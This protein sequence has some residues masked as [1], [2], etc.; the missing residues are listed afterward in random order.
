MKMLEWNRLW[1]NNMFIF[2]HFQSFDSAHFSVD[3]PSKQQTSIFR[4]SIYY[5]SEM[6]PSYLWNWFRWYSV[7][8]PLLCNRILHY[9]GAKWATYVY[10]YKG[11]CYMSRRCGLERSPSINVAYFTPVLYMLFFVTDALKL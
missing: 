5:L 8:F 7:Y 3:R 11:F 2:S 4:N 1:N 10:I 6:Y 9:E